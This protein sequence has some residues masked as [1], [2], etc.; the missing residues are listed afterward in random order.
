MAKIAI[1]YV[2]GVLSVKL[3]PEIDHHTS[4]EIRKE[5]DLSV[6]RFNAKK[7]IM[8]FS[9]VEFADSSAVGLLMGRYKL[10]DELMGTIEVVNLAGQ[11]R[12]V[13]EMSGIDR[14][15]SLK[16]NNI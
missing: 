4:E 16:E 7:I 15:I 2:S 14:L 5:I 6:V 1:N 13:L 9:G 8:D 10:M 3:P 12:K 11:C